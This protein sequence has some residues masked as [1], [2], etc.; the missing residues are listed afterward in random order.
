M[1]NFK[2]LLA[3]AMVLTMVTSVMPAPTDVNAATYIPAVCDDGVQLVREI[4][5]AVEDEGMDLYTTSFDEPL[6][7]KWGGVVQTEDTIYEYVAKNNNLMRISNII[8]YGCIDEEE[9]AYAQAQYIVGA[10]NAINLLY[11]SDTCIRLVQ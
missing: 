2:K 7:L 4:V 1:N 9:V 5:N 10:F 6:T 3:S 8:D 11:E